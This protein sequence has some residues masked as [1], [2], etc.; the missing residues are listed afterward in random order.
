MD[1]EGLEAEVRDG[2]GVNGGLGRGL[3]AGAVLGLG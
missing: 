3:G 1:G 2:C